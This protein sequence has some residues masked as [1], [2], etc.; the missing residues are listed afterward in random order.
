MRFKLVE[1]IELDESINTNLRKFLLAL[2]DLSGLDLPFKNPVVHHTKKDRGLNGI[3]DLVIMS[4][5]D[6]RSMHAK[7]RNKEWDEN[8]HKPYTFIEIKDILA[9]TMSKLDKIS[10]VEERKLEN[11]NKKIK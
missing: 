4:D 9:A 6:H 3:E 7:Y 2:I 8:A 5:H 11:E 10:N 1:N